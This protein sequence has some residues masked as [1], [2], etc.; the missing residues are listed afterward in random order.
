MEIRTENGVGALEIRV[1]PQAVKILAQTFPDET[2][3]LGQRLR[4]GAVGD[5]DDLSSLRAALDDDL[6]IARQSKMCGVRIRRHFRIYQS[7]ADDIRDVVYE[8][9]VYAAVRYMH[10]AVGTRL[11]Q[12]EFRC[13]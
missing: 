8:R 4:R 11:E 5:D 7:A 3:A 12:P 10:H 1:E 9:V 13:C 6:Q 2:R